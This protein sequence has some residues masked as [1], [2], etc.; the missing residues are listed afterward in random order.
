MAINEEVDLENI[1]IDANISSGMSISSVGVGGPRGEKGDKG[2]KGD[3]G[4]TGPANTLAIGTVAKGD[5]AAATITGTAPNQTL[6]LTLPKGDKGDTGEKGDKG[7]TGSTGPANS[8]S[9]GTVESGSTA[10]AT[11]T[12]TAPE[13]TLNLTL[14]KGDKGDTG[15]QGPQGVAGQD[16]KINGV[17]TLSI[18]AGDNISLAQSGGTLTISSTAGGS[19]EDNT[20]I[21]K[22]SQEKIQTVAVIDRNTGYADKTWIGTKQQYNALPVKDPNTLYY[23][24]DDTDDIYVTK[25]VND[26]VNYYTKTETFTKQEVNNLISA[27]TTMDIQVVQ[28]LPTEDIST[29]T[30]YLVPKTTAEQNDAYDEYIYVSNAWEHIGST[31]I[32]LSGYQTKIDSSHKLSSDLVDDTNKTNKFVTSAEKTTWNGKYTKP[33]GGIPKTDLASTVQTSL[34]KADTSIQ[35]S[36]LTDYVE[37]TDYANTNAAGVIKTSSTYAT[38]MTNTGVLYGDTITYANYP[39]TNAGAFISKGTLEN[40]ITGK[41]INP[42]IT[43]TQAEYDALA[44]KDPNVYY[45]IIEE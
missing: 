25:T 8:L 7:D 5:E 43:L 34:E 40:V 27:I 32:D 39:N 21:T 44:T 26:L 29:T 42:T 14:P 31:D 17:N 16:A 37:N 24:T 35:S 38:S 23:I 45:Y 30:I 3:T 10:A 15:S 9:I 19:E 18:A 41:G 4:A 2:D 1:T 28:T 13:Q 20:T 11:I 12:G 36:D 6:N 22:N 33:S